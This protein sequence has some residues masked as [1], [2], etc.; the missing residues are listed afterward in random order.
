[1]NDMPRLKITNADIER[2]KRQHILENL[3]YSVVEAAKMLGCSVRKV[4]RLIDSGDL[5]SGNDTPGKQ[6]T[7]ITALSIEKYNKKRIKLAGNE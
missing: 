7:V 6:G 1:M 5:V 3:S 2:V 4:Y